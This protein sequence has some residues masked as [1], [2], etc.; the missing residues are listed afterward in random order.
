MKKATITAAIIAATLTAG[1]IAQ[2]DS[3]TYPDGHTVEVIEH[4]DMQAVLGDVALTT[5][6]ND[7]G[8]WYDN[9]VEVIY[10][11][12]PVETPHLDAPTHSEPVTPHLDAPANI[13]RSSHLDNN[14]DPQ[15]KASHLD[16]NVPSTDKATHLDAPA[17]IPASTLTPATKESTTTNTGTTPTKP[18]T[19]NKT[20]NTGTTTTES[21][22]KTELNNAGNNGTKGTTTKSGTIQSSNRQSSV[23]PAITQTPAPTTQSTAQSAHV[24]NSSSPRRD[25][26]RPANI[27]KQSDKGLKDGDLIS[28]Q[29]EDFGGNKL[30]VTGSKD[31]L[32]TILTCVG[33]AVVSLITLHSIWVLTSPRKRRKNK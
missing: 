5:L 25:V 28:A 9:G 20:V 23:T 33:I 19:E 15:D 6:A 22:K 7:G 21:T 2:A 14:V 3:V 26:V 17:T 29:A 31:T 24:G 11:T 27:S 4:N 16:N 8:K 13:D 18:S 1:S 10:N 32:G 30:P 12:T